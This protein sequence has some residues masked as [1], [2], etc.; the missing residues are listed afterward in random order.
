MQ[1][2]RKTFQ[3]LAMLCV[4]L[5]VPSRMSGQPYYYWS[6]SENWRT[7]VWRL[8]LV[9]EVKE[10]FLQDT[11][12][13]DYALSTD[14][15]Q[16][17][18]FL[19]PSHGPFMV[20]STDNP[21]NRGFLPSVDAV[22][23]YKEIIFV[24]QLNRFYCS[25]FSEAQDAAHSASFDGS[26][27]ALEDTLP[28][29]PTSL[30][31]HDGSLMYI[32]EEDTLTHESYIDAFSS[33]TYQ[34]VHRKNELLIGPPTTYKFAFA[35]MGDFLLYGYQ[36]PQGDT[37][38]GKYQV[39]DFV[40]DTAYPAIPF[41]ARSKCFLSGDGSCVIIEE[42][43]LASVDSG[44]AEYRPG[45][46]YVFES[47]TARF[48]AH[49]NLP[50]NGE[51]MLFPNHPD[52]LYYYLPNE[53]RAIDIDLPQLR[54]TTITYPAIWNLV[55]VPRVTDTFK[56]TE[57]FPT[58]LP[59]ALY[60]Y[61]GAY[62]L[63]DTLQNGGGYWAGLSQTTTVKFTGSTLTQ[64]SRTVPS[65]GWWFVGSISQVVPVSHLTSSPPGSIV[66]VYG[67]ENQY[68]IATQLEPG[69]GYWVRVTGACT[70]TISQ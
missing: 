59:G 27:F 2:T 12:R 39:Y 48:V 56:G 28:F 49:L 26:T 70:L 57:L 8:N 38:N 10:Q 17:W 34:L 23:S 46:V 51:I 58:L 6:Q 25:W 54:T 61:N 52:T 37:L 63:V 32:G 47:R 4:I 50:P 66:A 29:V 69:K 36:Y 41:P 35:S 16:T 30:V 3:T 9:T 11:L 18:L 60:D 20:I 42:V 1:K 55:S 64:A 31:S 33:A 45:S 5:N 67:W 68:V 44:R 24:P 7:T 21:N 40:A 53:Q 19:E 62:Y 15:T 14:P 13:G 43:R 65:E 22:D